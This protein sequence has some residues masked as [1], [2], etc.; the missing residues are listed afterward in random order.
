MMSHKNKQIVL[1]LSA[2]VRKE[3]NQYS[4]WCPELDVASCG[5]T[6]EAACSS[7]DEALDLYIA[8]LEEEGELLQVLTERGL[9]PEHED[10]GRCA[11]PFLSVR[12]KTVTVPV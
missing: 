11:Y 4:S 7:L 3:G 9:L 8:T 6:V 1:E 2:V 12:R 10:A 5:D